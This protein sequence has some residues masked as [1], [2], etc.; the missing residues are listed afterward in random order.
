MQIVGK[1]TLNADGVE[2]HVG[3]VLHGA[4]TDGTPIEEIEEG[5]EKARQSFISYCL[6][7]AAQADGK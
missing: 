1:T 5:L 3:R 4:L 7:A 6:D 2:V